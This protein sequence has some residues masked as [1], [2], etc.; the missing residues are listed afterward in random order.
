MNDDTS[1][2][3]KN[4]KLSVNQSESRCCAA[5]ADDAALPHLGYA[6]AGAR[7]CHPELMADVTGAPVLALISIFR[8]ISV[9][10]AL[11]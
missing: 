10:E 7:R 4:A 3:R 5:A 1:P 9:S 8:R 11:I 2:W 6:P